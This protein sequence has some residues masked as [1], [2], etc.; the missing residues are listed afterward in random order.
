M[1]PLKDD[2][3]RRYWKANERLIYVL[4]GIWA[5][6]SLGCGVL[7]VEPLN[8]FQFLGLPLGFFIAQQGSIYVFVAI[9]FFYAW[10]M[11]RLDHAYHADED[12]DG[13]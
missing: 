1:E 5:V 7:F 11:D 3:L 10:A 2:R 13:Q 8:R 6:V 4:L 9:I 12:G